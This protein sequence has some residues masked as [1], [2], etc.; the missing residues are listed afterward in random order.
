MKITSL[1]NVIIII[2]LKALL[3]LLVDSSPSEMI[4]NMDILY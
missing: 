4:L 2:I 3:G 1:Y